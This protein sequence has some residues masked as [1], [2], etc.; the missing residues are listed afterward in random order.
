MHGE[1]ATHGH[2][3]ALLSCPGIKTPKSSRLIVVS[4]A[5]LPGSSGHLTIDDK[6][7]TLGDIGR[8]SRPSHT[9][10]GKIEKSM[11]M[12]MIAASGERTD[13]RQHFRAARTKGAE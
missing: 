13:A 10:G 7:S 11:L 1:R 6:A 3:S 5:C 12:I 4:P 2:G 9:D 8:S